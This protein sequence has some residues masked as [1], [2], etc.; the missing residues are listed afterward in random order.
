M[1]GDLQRRCRRRVRG[2]VAEAGRYKVSGLAVDASKTQDLTPALPFQSRLTGIDHG[3][4]SDPLG[5]I[6]SWAHLALDN[7]RCPT[8][9]PPACPFRAL[10]DERLAH[11]P[12]VADV[13][14]YVD[15]MWP[16]LQAMRDLGGSAPN[17]EIDDKVI[18]LLGI[19]EKVQAVPAG[20]G[21][22]RDTKLKLSLRW[23]RTNL[24]AI[25]AADNSTKG[26]WLLTDLGESLTR[27]RLFDPPQQASSLASTGKDAHA[28]ERK[29]GAF[30][31]GS[32]GRRSARG[33][34]EGR[35][36]RRADEDAP[37][38]V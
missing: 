9:S 18:E 26:F 19:S 27:R 33:K 23:A 30:Y 25:G 13:P 29:S 10:R 16:T 17:D 35:V 1:P 3:H 11:N 6:R 20:G 36:A 21:R 12:R 38:R 8:R 34:L 22:R 2:L 32:V 14:T 4:R 31:D 5:L 15:L 28:K 37:G 7:E 24:K